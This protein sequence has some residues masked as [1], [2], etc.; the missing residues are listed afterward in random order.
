MVKTYKVVD[1][2]GLHARPASLMVGQA[3]KYPDEVNILFN[4]KKL[5]LKSIMAVMSLGVPCGEEF[6]IEV[7]GENEVELFEKL[8]GILI[9]HKV[10]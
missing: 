7:V 10:I 8:E 3:T 4:E 1:E 9:E 5:T 2:A 6:S